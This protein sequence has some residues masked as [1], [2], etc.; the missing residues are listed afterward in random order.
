[1]H[2]QPR[3]TTEIY[4]SASARD[5]FAASLLSWLS[6]LSSLIDTN[7]SPLVGPSARSLQPPRGRREDPWLT[8]ALQGPLLTSR[9]QLESRVTAAVLTSLG[10][11]AAAARADFPALPAQQTSAGLGQTSPPAPPAPSTTSSSRAS[12]LGSSALDWMAVHTPSCDSRPPRRSAIGSWRP[13][14]LRGTSPVVIAPMRTSTYIQL[15]HASTLPRFTINALAPGLLPVPASTYA[16]ALRMR[17][18]LNR[19]TDIDMLTEV[20]S[21]ALALDASSM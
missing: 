12:S 8:V 11:L 18:N 1:M 15:R 10:D 13:H 20:L 4:M 19:L 9:D 21:L 2:G 17:G 7:A 6:P 14:T 16:Q 5:Q 3:P